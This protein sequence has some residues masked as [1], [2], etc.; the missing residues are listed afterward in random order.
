MKKLFS[1][2][3]SLLHPRFN[4]TLAHDHTLGAQKI[5]GNEGFRVKRRKVSAETY[6]VVPS[7]QYL[8]V[9]NNCT[10]TLMAASDV[11]DGYMV[12][13]G[14]AVPGT[15]TVTVNP[16]GSDTIGGV[17]GPVTLATSVGFGI[18]ISDGVDNW[19]A[20]SPGVAPG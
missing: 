10:V 6:T 14:N 19:E 1:I 3:L 16:A 7:D 2:L 13:V 9:I 12:M 15:Y 4:V 5:P 8:G 18:F 11:P 17:A 20:M